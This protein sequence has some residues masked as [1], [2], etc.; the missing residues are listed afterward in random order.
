MH[1]LAETKTSFRHPVLCKTSPVFSNSIV[2]LG[3]QWEKNK[4]EFN[5]S[6][7]CRAVFKAVNRNCLV[8]ITKSLALLL[9]SSVNLLICWIVETKPLMIEGS[10]NL[11]FITSNSPESHE[12]LELCDLLVCLKFDFIKKKK[13]TFGGEKN[14][15]FIAVSYFL[16]YFKNRVSP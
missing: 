3:I 10:S 7:C 13:N 15:I 1:W 2:S 5:I 12:C 16:V 14:N 11:T 4:K 9:W 8:L 6:W